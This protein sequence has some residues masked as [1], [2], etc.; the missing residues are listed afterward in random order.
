MI[1]CGAHFADSRM[2]DLLRV[3][4]AEPRS[5]EKPVLCYG[6]LPSQLSM[7]N[8]EALEISWKTLG[9]VGFVDFHALRKKPVPIW[10]TETPTNRTIV[11]LSKYNGQYGDS[12]PNEA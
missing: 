7:T 11:S 12:F 6:D 3:V 5:R 2:F 9:A 4:K 10:P 1:L 8:F